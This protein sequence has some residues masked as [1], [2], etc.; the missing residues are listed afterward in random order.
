MQIQK[1]TGNDLREKKIDQQIVQ[2]SECSTK[3]RPG[4]EE[5]WRLEEESEEDAVRRRVYST[6]TASAL[7]RELLK[8]W[9]TSKWEDK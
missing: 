6:C 3:P 1:G 7:P 2:G 4:W 8:R 9:E 5:A